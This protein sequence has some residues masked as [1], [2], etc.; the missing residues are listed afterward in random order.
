M[1]PDDSSPA[2]NDAVGWY[3]DHTEAVVA[4]HESL[5]PKKVNARLEKLLPS[6]PALVL[7]VGAGS[8]RDAAWL[9]SLGH[10]VIAVER[11]ETMR[12]RGRRLHAADRI[13]WISDRL[14][15]L[16]KVARELALAQLKRNRLFCVWDRTEA[17]GGY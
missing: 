4:R 9:A 2:P 13:R 11:A 3:D 1:S 8:G 17:Q 16:E 10:Q 7:D 5:T 6:Q 14:P 15:G 12:V